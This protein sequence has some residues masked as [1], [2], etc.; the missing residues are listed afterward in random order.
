M[1]L[2]GTTNYFQAQPSLLKYLQNSA[3]EI[4]IK[5]HNALIE[6]RKL[7]P[8]STELSDYIQKFNGLFKKGV[9][10][11]DASCGKEMIAIHS[12]CACFDTPISVKN[13]TYESSIWTQ[14]VIDIADAYT[15]F[16]AERDKEERMERNIERD[17]VPDMSIGLTQGGEKSCTVL[18][19]IKENTNPN[20]DKDIFVEANKYRGKVTK[21]AQDLYE[22]RKK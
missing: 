20:T 17:D 15:D 3:N 1:L 7:C 2:N 13:Q 16:L 12:T 21:E 5:Y 19:H 8:E 10:F 9:E 22:E 14:I 4:N 6:A 11:E 18:S